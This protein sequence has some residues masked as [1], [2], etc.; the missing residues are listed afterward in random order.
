MANFGQRTFFD[1]GSPDLLRALKLQLVRQISQCLG[2]LRFL[3]VTPTIENE[4]V[5]P[6]YASSTCKNEAYITE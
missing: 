6:R 1:G 4:V 5:P 3:F 2:G